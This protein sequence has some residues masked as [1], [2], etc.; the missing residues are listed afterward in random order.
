[1]TLT[2]K[3]YFMSQRS[4]Q[5]EIAFLSGKLGEDILQADYSKVIAKISGLGIEEKE[6]ILAACVNAL[7]GKQSKKNEGTRVAAVRAVVALLPLSLETIADLLNRRQNRHHYEVHFTLFCYLDWVQEMPLAT[8][9]TKDVLLRVEKYLMTVPRATA[10]AVWMAGDM[11][12]DHWNEQEAIPLLMRGA[13][14][15]NY[16]V[17]RQSSL[18]GLEKILERVSMEDDIHKDI[19]KM[20][21]K[22]SLSDHSHYVQED[23][24]ALLKH[25]RRSNRHE[26]GPS[27]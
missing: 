21:H 8:S 14:S 24:K 3:N 5:N 2:A 4:L 10:R 25:W 9:L 26:N 19:L 11:L 23:A 1:M 17:G 18:L 6:T 27:A 20:T 13:Q 16:S 12:G 22:V 15:A 7:E